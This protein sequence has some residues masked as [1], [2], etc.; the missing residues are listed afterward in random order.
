MCK[1]LS[2]LLLVLLLACSAVFAARFVPFKEAK[3][4]IK[5][6]SVP[7]NQS[8]QDSEEPRKD[9]KPLESNSEAMQNLTLEQS[10]TRLQNS[11]T[12]Q[13]N[14]PEAVDVVASFIA[15]LEEEKIGLEFDL[16]AYKQELELRD[17]SLTE[18][19]KEIN[20]LHLG[21]GFGITYNPVVSPLTFGTDLKI[22]LRKNSWIFMMGVGFQDMRQTV[23]NF[24][25]GNLHYSA[26]FMYEF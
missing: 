17:N 24:N 3:M 13:K 22:S 9:V 7:T 23:K 14:E 5:D 20:R 6:T 12:V 10:I 19:E 21:L 18:K 26:S 15:K 25:F 16:A 1:K 2:V 11:K 8:F 4:E